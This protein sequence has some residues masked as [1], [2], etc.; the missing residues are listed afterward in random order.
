MHSRTAVLAV[1][2]VTW[3]TLSAC[4]IV[5]VG[6]KPSACRCACET[7]CCY[8]EATT[9]S[10][11]GCF[12]YTGPRGLVKQFKAAC[13]GKQSAPTVYAVGL[14]MDGA[15]TAGPKTGVPCVAGGTINAVKIP[16]DSRC[17]CDR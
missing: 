10:V 7:A 3:A 16:D 1:G 4:S 8:V 14:P 9:V 11:G 13:L 12:E 6:P 17:R 2:L 5:K 15:C